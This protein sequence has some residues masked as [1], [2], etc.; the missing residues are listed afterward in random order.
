VNTVENIKFLGVDRQNYFVH[1]SCDQYNGGPSIKFVKN[2]LVPFLK[3]HRLKTS[4]IISD[5]RQPRHMGTYHACIPG[6]F[7]YQSDLPDDIKTGNPWI[8][9]T[10]SPIWVR[11]NIG[12]PNSKAGLPYQDPEGF[13]KWLVKEFGKPGPNNTI[14]VFGLTLDCCILAL[15]QELYWRGYYTK[16]LV[17]GTDVMPGPDQGKL[18]KQIISGGIYKAWMK[19]IEFKELKETIGNGKTIDSNIKQL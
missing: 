13:T 15:V 9:C 12:I 19:F 11:D 1:K 18:K 6:E 14:I 4:E 5:Y 16:V 2:Q 7:D 10:N 3:H 17:E 8:K